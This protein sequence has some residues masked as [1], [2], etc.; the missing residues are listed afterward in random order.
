MSNFENFPSNSENLIAAEQLQESQASVSNNSFENF[1]NSPTDLSESAHL[2][3]LQTSVTTNI[4]GI[5]AATGY[6]VGAIAV[7]PS[8]FFKSTEEKKAEFVEDVNSYVTSSEFISCLSNDLGE[9]KVTETEEDF[10][11]RASRLLKATLTEKF[12]I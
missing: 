3:E 8:F 12:K 10:V 5:L 4:T 1:L 6:A 9:P 2:Q 7:S 11:E